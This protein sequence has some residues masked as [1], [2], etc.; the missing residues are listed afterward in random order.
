MMQVYCQD[1]KHSLE[2]DI[3]SKKK[4]KNRLN[5]PSHLRGLFFG[6]KISKET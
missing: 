4:D 1:G 6:L 5:L 2:L 3:F